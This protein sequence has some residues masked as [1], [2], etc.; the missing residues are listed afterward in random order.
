MKKKLDGS[1]KYCTREKILLKMKLTLTLL[2]FCLVSM[3]ASTYSQTVR[4]DVTYN[5]NDM[6]ELF[7]LL[8]EKSEFYFFYQ[9]EDLINLNNISV[10]AK[11][12][13]ITEILDDVIKGTSI[14]YKVVDRYV[15]IRKANDI[16]VEDSRQPIKVS[17]KVTDSSGAPLPG[18][19]VVVKGTTQGTITN[20]EGEYS[21]SNVPSNAILVFSFVGMRSQEIPVSGKTQVNIILVEELIGLDE[22]VAV[23]YGTQR[24]RDITGAISN[25]NVS[26]LED[27]P[28]TNVT[29]LLLGQ[30]TGVTVKQS[31]G[32][33]GKEFEVVI[34][35][36]SSLGASS[37]P[38]YVIDGFP[39]G[40][41]I[42][43]NLDVSDIE[44]ITILKDGVSTAIYG[45]GG[46]SGVILITTK[47]AKAGK[48]NLN[49]TA[50]YGIQNIPDSRKVKMLNGEEFAQFKKD[51]FMDKIRL[52]ENREPSIEE[53]PL[54]YRYP[55]Q[56]KISTNWYDAIL[57]KNAKLQHY[58]LTF[59]EGDGDIHTRVSVGMI[60][61]E[62]ALLNTNYDNISVRANIRGKI[63]NFINIGL[64]INGSYS[65]Q[66]Y[67]DSESYYGVVG[68]SLLADP[69]EPIYNEDGS[70]NDY[71]GGHDG[72]IGFFNPVQYLYEY[73]RKREISDLLSTGFI[74]FAFLKNF[75]FKSAVNAKRNNN[76]QKEFRPSTLSGTTNSPAPRD[77]TLA[78][79]TVNMSN[80]AIDQLLTYN[81]EFENHY[82]NIL[83]GFSAQ[84]EIT[85]VLKGSG[86]QFP[87]NLT[88]FLG[89]AT[90]SSSTS[91]E[92]GWS[93]LAYFSR[94]NYSFKDKYL[95]SSTFRREGSSKFGTNNKY[96]NFPAA[97][98]GWRIS[99]E[100]FMSGI[101]WLND[102]KVRVSWGETGNNNIG[103]YSHLA[104]MSQN[105]YILG[106]NIANGYV[107]ESFGN[108]ELGW[109]KSKQ[110]DIGVDLS[111]FNNK[112]TF[113][114]DY[115]N[116]ITSDML[117][118][119]QVPAISGF[120]SSLGNVGKVE[121]KGLEFEFGYKTKI[122]E[123]GLR[124]TFN[125][126]FN[127]NK[128]LE[129]RGENDEV[130]DGSTLY[131]GGYRSKVG[132]PI[133]MIMGYK[134]L[135]IF[136][137]YQEIEES[138]VQDGAIPGDL[139]YFDASGD[140]VIS[141]GIGDDWVEIGNPWPKYTWGLTLGGD[142]KNFD[143]NVLLTGAMD[144][145]IYRRIEHSTLNLDGVFNV[146]SESKE[147]WRSE[148]NPGAGK[149]SGT[150]SWKWQ[151]EANSN[152][153]YDGSHLWVKNV[154]LGYTLPKSIF[155]YAGI[156]I[157]MS[158]DNLFV[159]TNYPGNNPDVSNRGEG[160][161]PS[162]DSEA[163]PVPR[164]FFIGANITF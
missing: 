92:Y 52:L 48:V 108:A 141:Y 121:N 107:V 18:V 10:D 98:V 39:I 42:G 54:D 129:M 31:T 81:K 97:S 123:I 17:G 93:M 56:T 79:Q 128:V 162:Y 119:I 21:L 94:I 132:R 157:Y 137:N 117:L 14:D 63:N 152:Y 25:I 23:G 105:G 146:L 28:A 35:G 12:A 75:K 41:S 144:F 154:S 104:F 3:G 6:V 76:S 82:L 130:W 47:K 136:N 99:E 125:I 16:R 109:E 89:S 103:N 55:E 80:Y 131:D 140:G 73:D 102:L 60:N 65:K 27:I 156:R 59:S 77:A 138:P 86:S 24:K 155:R 87:N 124:S 106:D 67:T 110:L 8:E 120:T 13:T 100:S 44:S 85:K 7:K 72:L 112:L 20:I 147:R 53:V 163:Y 88:P 133:G 159:I 69:R 57:N 122:N 62:G 150:S 11:N 101:S 116:K 153:V 126:S 45:A 118:S 61:Q 95:L 58:N 2:T 50:K 64:N 139:K 143:L 142:Y 149:I 90:L 96:G 78:E 84:E 49:F 1:G 33:P 30:S 164:T 66:K 151:R 135:G 114:A 43:Q 160:L 91:S 115:Y 51:V 22:V 145:D 161:N 68:V 37:D 15:I 74:E 158:A 113:T 34:R 19:T 111:A 5:G 127:R 4:F 26:G 83:L 46:S 38:L 70:F 32:A 36:V 29:K 71:I 148:E 40:T 134:V 9:K